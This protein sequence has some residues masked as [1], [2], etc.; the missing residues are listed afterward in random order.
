MTISE[1]KIAG[2]GLPEGD[3][4]FRLAFNKA[5]LGMCLVDL[6]GNIIQANEKM[7]LIFGYAQPELESMTVNDLAVPEDAA[8]SLQFI[9]HAIAGNEEQKIF[10]KHYRHRDGRIIHAQVASSLVRD[11]SGQALYFISQVQDITEQKQAEDRLRISEQRHRLLA[12]NARDVIW[13]MEID[14]TISYVS[15]SVEHV[16]GFTPE[17]AMQQPME[18]IL[19]PA[20]LASAQ[21]YFRGLY[22]AMAA[23]KPLESYRGDQEYWCKDGS[24]FWSEVM[25]FPL[26]NGDGSLNQ[27]IGVTRDIS[28]RKRHEEELKEAR[29]AT[30]AANRALQE[31]N[32]EL[33][34]HRDQLEQ[35]VLS[36]TQALA[37]ARDE[38]ESANA[39]KTRFM[40]NVS[41]EMRTPLQGILGFAEIG[42]SR[43]ASITPEL[44][45][46]YFGR[47]LESG[48]RMHALV[49]SLL[50]L[51]EQAWVEQSGLAGTQLQEIDLNAFVEE[52][53]LLMGLRAEKNRQH[54][55]LE[56]PTNART[57]QGDAMRLR[58][59]FE[60]LI[61]N[62]LRYS[63][64]ESTVTLQIND[65][66]LR[67]SNG[68][69]PVPAIAFNVMDK[70]CGIP[71]NEIK[72]IF[73]PFY[74]STRTANGAG[75][76]GLG[77]SLS[78]SIVQRHRGTLTLSNQ[79]EG[80]V[81]C[82]VTLP[83]NQTML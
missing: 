76:T 8:L 77:L 1:Q 24:T 48:Q 7:S 4:R 6:N 59:V 49:E 66:S 32:A 73:E 43:A 12:D 41:H 81:I 78:R 61:G 56:I 31:A 13:T 53:S 10:E 62:A 5:N 82:T 58:Q 38:A 40:A 23:G 9:G 35:L 44:A 39:V 45:K 14:G 80:G 37:I 19:T 52:I 33:A 21:G 75:G 15:P 50:C 18:E 20:S 55:V 65:S 71:E 42:E 64:P 54:L 46:R 57:F 51:T 47:I 36:R 3:E 26:L 30:E 16:R 63:Q 74:Q 2:N 83:V 28:E 60:H 29:D 11:A 70:G 25:A 72:A 69:E 79:P 34:R 67:A 27:I 17:E 68:G 22:E